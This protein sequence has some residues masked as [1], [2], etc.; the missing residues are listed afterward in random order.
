MPTL[1][2]IGKKA[3][4]NHHREV[5]YHVLRCDSALS[6]GEPG[7]GNLL[8]QGDNL[9]ALKALLPYYAGKVKC[10]FIDPP[11]NT[12]NEGW[13]YNDNTN[14]PEIRQWLGKVVGKDAEDLSR[15]D[16]WLCMM[17]PRVALLRQFLAQDGAIA[18]TLDD[19]E[20]HTFRLLMDEVFGANNFV[21]TIV[22]QKK[23][24]SSNDH[25]GIAPMHDYV[26]VYRR[27]EGF[28]RNLVPRPKSKD[29]QYKYEDERGVFRVSDYTCNKTAD[30][31]PNLYYP[32]KQPKTGEEV[33]P[34]RT[35]V[36]AYSE[37]VHKQHVADDLIFWGKSGDA[38]VPA[39]KRYRHLLR[40][41]DGVVPH[42]WWDHEFAGHTDAAKK[43][44][45]ALDVTDRALDFVTPKPTTLLER[46][47]E[48]LTDKDSIV[49]DS[50]AGS[51]TTGHA[52]LKANQADCGSRRFILIEMDEG[53][54][55][56]ITAERMRRVVSGYKR[57]SREA[58]A[59]LGGGYRFCR[60]G[61]SLLDANGQV[62][63]EIKFDDLARHVWFCETGE[64]WP[65]TG[66][67][68]RSPL[69]GTHSDTGVYLLFNGVLGDRTVNGGNVLTTSVLAALPKHKGPKVIYGEASRLG[70]ERLKREG[71]V[72]K[73]IPYEVKGA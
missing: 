49:L 39:F 11:Y 20:C 15:H 19:N 42:T 21:A 28:H 45:R 17:Y 18:A 32:I 34:K 23:Y 44:I 64:P 62:A 54:C 46:V 61:P 67:G 43:E 51:G 57:P 71:I 8:V 56:S 40:R 13:V 27:S 35:R 33:W 24:A 25:T 1:D 66:K 48:V 41:G 53:I 68:K 9:L 59:G 47:L 37:E 3:V 26:I 38:V 14:S 72:F 55:Q 30:E 6:V 12:G 7:S 63:A 4:V 69:L 29:R 58:V 70:K 5:P 2:W 22:W 10:I 16:K 60:L 52:V 73:Q 31:R 50:F 36:W 65:V